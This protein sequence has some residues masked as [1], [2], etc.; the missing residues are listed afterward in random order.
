MTIPAL[1]SFADLQAAQTPPPAQPNFQ[2]RSAGGDMNPPTQ[3][4][5]PGGSGFNT[6]P[7]TPVPAAQPPAQPTQQQ[8][9]IAELERMGRIPV[10]QFKSERELFDAMYGALEQTATELEQYRQRPPVTPAAP[11]QP[12]T[13]AT[14]AVP[15]DDL[16]K[17][18]TVFQQNNWL[19]L[20]N[21]QW[22]ATNPLATQVAQQLNTQ[23]LEAQARQAELADPRSFISKY[24]KEVFEQA[25][26]PLQEQMKQVLERNQRLE[27]QLSAM[28]PKPHESWIKEHEAK[29]WT[30]DPA[31]TRVPTQAGAAYR[32][33]WD[34]AANSGVTDPTAA[35][36]IAS[37][38]A[39]AYLQSTQ[40]AAPPQPQQPWLQQAL[41]RPPVSDPSF[42]AAGTVLNNSVPPQQRGVPLD[43]Q[44]FPTFAGLQAIGLQ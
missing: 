37:M 13:P 14:P 26:S 9:S 5:Q 8:F 31:G 43:N 36:Q 34:L 17:M 7:A 21:G 38:A 35:H 12:A 23:A 16:T 19:A 32:D 2:G 3:V 6:P 39:S 1:P 28:T 27:M 41:Q 42:N 44:G 18:A 40:P 10:G 33:A 15:A 29:L 25:L 22:V 30:T 24:G 11:V 20:Q 4:S